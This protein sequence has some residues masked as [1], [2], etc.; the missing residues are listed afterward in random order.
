MAA[1]RD[2]AR[3]TVFVGDIHGC[4]DD[5][6][7]LLALVGWSAPSE[8][9]PAA[10]SPRIVSV[11]DLV[12]KGP[13]S[14]GVVRF[15][16]EN[17][18]EAVMGN[19]DYRVLHPMAGTE[20]ERIRAALSADDV[21]WLSAMPLWLR[22][23]EHNILAVHAGVPPD[24]SPDDDSLAA[25]DA[26]DL[27]N[28]RSV[29]P[30][31]K[32]SASPDEGKPWAPLWPGPVRVV[33]GHDAVRG[34]Q[35]EKFAVGLDTGCCYGNQ[36]SALVMPDNVVLTVPSSCESS[37]PDRDLGRA[38]TGSDEPEPRV[39]YSLDGVPA[40]G[41]AGG[42]GGADTVPYVCVNGFA[43][44]DTEGGNAAGVVAPEHAVR[45]VGD[46]KRSAMAAR[47]G[48]SETVFVEEADAV[49]GVPCVK[50]AFFTPGGEVELCGHAT[51]ASMGHL[52]A[53]GAVPTKAGLVYAQ[54]RAGRVRVEHDGET[55]R[56]EQA[57][58]AFDDAVELTASDVAAVLNVDEAAVLLEPPPC[59]VSTGLRDIF[60][61]LPRPVLEGLAVDM[62][63]LTALSVRVDTVGLHAFALPEGA[64]EPVLVRNFA[65]RF[66]IDEE[67]AT[68]T[69][70]CALGCLLATRTPGLA[71]ARH[72]SEV[73]FCFSQG[74]GMGQPSLI[75]VAVSVDADA[76]EVVAKPW[77]GG[78]WRQ[79]EDAAHRPA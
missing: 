64:G 14:V 8:S 52:I 43:V 67:S 23:P 40:E 9:A 65:P 39:V 63:A 61:R 53:E 55:V 32:V 66:G 45:L 58:P 42:A 6:K 27:M 30:G 1:A 57:V 78:R 49:D 15:C 20:H 54:T 75:H 33:F 31:G 11:G 16:R 13:D 68:G 34:L 18:I 17:G 73:R 59:V 3:R 60:V 29:L 76:K 44:S 38:D 26:N 47:L 48:Y 51:I 41:A 37:P 77:V 22:V 12:A 24:V 28:M 21:S 5:F 19:H 2:V 70:N 25:V 56:M 50:L 69:S 4:L 36:L 74:W 72:G 71:G 10:Q 62:E 79:V 46:G 7:T 35:R